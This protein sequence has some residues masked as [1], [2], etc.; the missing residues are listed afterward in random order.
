MGA[1]INQNGYSDGEKKTVETPAKC[2]LPGNKGLHT[3]FAEYNETKQVLK[4]LAS[5][6]QV[7]METDKSPAVSL[8]SFYSVLYSTHTHTH[9]QLRNRNSSKFYFITFQLEEV[10]INIK[11]S[12]WGLE[13]WLSG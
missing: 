2:F 10:V 4:Y 7:C 12:R 9:T 3:V 8:T 6:I 13:R 5:F 1:G 11:M